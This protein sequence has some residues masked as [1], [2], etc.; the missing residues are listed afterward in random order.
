MTEIPPSEAS[1]LPTSPAEAL[2]LG[3]KHLKHGRTSDAIAILEPLAKRFPNTPKLLQA[4]ATAFLRD[5]Q[6][7]RGLD[8][9]GQLISASPGDAAALLG[10]GLCLHRLGN[11]ASALATF[12]ELV[13]L[14]PLSWRGWSSI[15]DIT[16][17]EDDRINAIEGAADALLVACQSDSAAPDL[18][19]QAAEAFLN[20]RKPG[21]ARRLL[22]NRG[23]ARSND[24]ALLYLLA[25]SHAH[26]GHFA[27]A[28]AIAA[29]LLSLPAT[30][31]PDKACV[32]SFDPG[33]AVSA[34]IEIQS[35]L[36]SAGVRSF[37]AGGTL[38]GFH[39]NG[40]PLV[41]DRDIDIGVLRRPDGGP[42]IAGIL[43]AHPGILLPAISRPGDRYFGLMH[44]GIAAD[45]FLHDQQD[46]HF[47][48]GFSA[49]PGDIQWRLGAFT[50]KTVSYGGRIFTVPSNPELYLARTYGPDWQTPDPGFAS[51]VSSPA[52]YGTDPFARSY[53]AL[54]RAWRARASGDLQKAAALLRQSPIPVSPRRLD[55]APDHRL[56]DDRLSD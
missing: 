5:G 55:T 36:A 42:D 39:R 26:Q 25:R 32:S 11:R 38:L 12:R 40:G 50:L 47:L 37:L 3:L 22:E 30:P 9:F 15:A 13:C 44:K 41:H 21:C 29:R 34:L 20:A 33:R 24:P 31:R 7:A 43:R 6:P 46:N 35:V 28:F 18:V 19:C 16:P 49:L 52:L 54:L 14:D 56:T 48:F 4:L 51:A 17:H 23:A 10:R 8:C 53:Y 1:S 2:Q 45:I 27:D